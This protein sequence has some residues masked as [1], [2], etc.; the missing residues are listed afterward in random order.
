MNWLVIKVVIY[1]YYECILQL[2]CWFISYIRIYNS[3]LALRPR[4]PYLFGGEKAAKAAKGVSPFGIPLV[5]GR[6]TAV[7]VATLLRRTVLPVALAKRGI[8]A[9]DFL[10]APAMNSG[11]SRV[12]CGSLSA[13]KSAQREQ[14]IWSARRFRAPS[15]AAQGKGGIQRRENPLVF[16]AYFLTTKSM[17]RSGLRTIAIIKIYIYESISDPYL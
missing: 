2:Y 15:P 8:L 17:G 3:V 10:S 14:A 6:A 1:I 5:K 13:I 16:F 11:V 7:R 9:R 4:G 12:H